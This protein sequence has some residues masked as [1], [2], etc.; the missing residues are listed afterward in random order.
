MNSA[1]LASFEILDPR[2]ERPVSPAS[3]RQSPASNARQY[4]RSLPAGRPD[5]HFG[6]AVRALPTGT[7]L[8]QIEPYLKPIHETLCRARFLRRPHVAEEA[9]RVR[10]KIEKQ[11]RRGG[12][13]VAASETSLPI[14][15]PRRNNPLASYVAATPKRS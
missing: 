15:C 8:I 14:T 12:S 2:E 9:S 4:H 1:W 11:H 3:T 7:A 5:R 10:N 13:R 6:A